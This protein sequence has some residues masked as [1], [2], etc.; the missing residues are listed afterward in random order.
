MW[1]SGAGC[2]WSGLWLVGS[3]AW[4]GGEFSAS[5]RVILA[6]RGHGGALPRGGVPATSLRVFAF[7][8][9]W[10]FICWLVAAGLV[11]GVIAPAACGRS[12]SPR[13]SRGRGAAAGGWPRWRARHPPRAAPRSGRRPLAPGLGGRVA[14]AEVADRAH[15]ARQ[16]VAQVAAGELEAADGLVPGPAVRVAV[17]P[18]EGDGVFA[19]VVGDDARV[20]DGGAA[21]VAPRYLMA[22]APLPKGLMLTL[23]SLRQAAGSTCQPRALRARRMCSRKES[24]SGA[25]CTRKFAFFTLT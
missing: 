23:Q 13:R 1:T 11:S 19:L 16:H 10:A 14:E 4:H 3:G 22:L 20:A 18:G 24:A 9:R 25:M 17:F 6:A 7:A 2:C 8:Y 15:A 21:D 12:S 5:I